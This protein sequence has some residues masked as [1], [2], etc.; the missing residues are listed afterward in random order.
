MRP[1]PAFMLLLALAAAAP[2]QTLPPI[3]VPA[4][5]PGGPLGLRPPPPPPPPPSPF[6]ANPSPLNPCVPDSW[7]ASSEIAYLFPQIV[8]H[9]T[10]TFSVPSADL[11]TG[12]AYAFEVGHRLPN[13]EG[14]IVGAFRF[15]NA[16]GTDGGV[17]SRLAVNSFLLDF[18]TPPDEFAPRYTASWRIGARADQLYFDSRQVLAGGQVFQASNNFVGGGIHGRVDLERRIVMIPGLSLFGRLDGSVL[19]G[20]VQ[21][22]YR[23]EAA[24]AVL[25]VRN[26]RAVPTVQAQVGLSYAPPALPGWKFTGGYMFE[27]YWKIGTLGINANG[28]V[29]SKGEAWWHGAFL[30]AQYDF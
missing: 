18:G 22:R 11:D 16:E 23:D 19:V 8:G 6:E 25:T 26:S 12:Y 10:P 2:A 15:L 20:S 13:K 3:P 1:S 14:E 21:Q 5:P 9:G 27:E 30:R 28:G 7:F 24:G 29:I 17:T 4:P